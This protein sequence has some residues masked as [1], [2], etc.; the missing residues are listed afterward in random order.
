MAVFD[1][2]Q[3][4]K[5]TVKAEKTY[6]LVYTSEKISDATHPIMILEDASKKL[7]HHSNGMFL[8]PTKGTAFVYDEEGEESSHDI[9]KLDARFEN[10]MKWLGENRIMVCLS[11]Q[12]TEEG[13]AVYKI[14]ETGVWVRGSNLS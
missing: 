3:T 13:Y 8:A 14:L 9:K 7:V 4:K 1:F 5:D 2:N 10:L 12:S 6:E 11:G